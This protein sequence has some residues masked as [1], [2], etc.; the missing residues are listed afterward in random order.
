[1][2]VPDWLQTDVAIKLNTQT[3]ITE[4]REAIYEL[5]L[6]NADKFSRRRPSD[7]ASNTAENI[8]A[9]TLPKL[10]KGS[11]I[12]FK[13]V[14]SSFIICRENKGHY[15]NCG[16]ENHKGASCGVDPVDSRVY[17]VGQSAKKQQ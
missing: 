13:K 4:C 7:S 14:R 11:E 5:I 16:N 12:G 9:E 17:P 2:V 10:Q 8:R 6:N 3:D 1:M 15:L